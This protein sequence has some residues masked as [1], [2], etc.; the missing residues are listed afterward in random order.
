MANDTPEKKLILVIGATGAQGLAVIDGLLK[1]SADGS[2]SP[3]TIRALTR[4]P[5][6]TRAKEL[7]NRGVQVF[8]GSV[9]DFNSILAALEGVYG[10][11]VNTD[12]FTIG[13]MKEV[14]YG[15]RIFELAKQVGTL[16]HY[17]WSALDYSFKL[18]GYNPTYRAEHYDAKGR[19]ND[20]LRA[21]PHAQ[22]LYVWTVEQAGGRNLRLRRPHGQWPRPDDLAL[23]RRFFA[24]YIFEHR[25]STSAQEL[26]VASDWVDWPYLVST[27]TKVTGKPAV[28]LPLSMDE[29]FGLWNQ[30]D[31][32]LPVMNTKRVADGSTTWE[33]NFRCWWA[34]YR[35]DIVKRDFEWIRKLHPG[36]HTLESWMRETGYDGDLLKNPLKNVEDGKFP[37]LEL[38]LA[39]KL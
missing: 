8:K 24:R 36:G 4:S 25:E 11:Y 33:Q 23:R 31:I 18:G 32:K 30:D 13:E 12:S 7:A 19:I 3:Y 29:W 26:E 21:Q 22:Q 37:R 14:Y 2:P 5:E 15:M 35:D 27:F 6:S 34:Q 28:Y 39:Q 38:S 1:P 10:A 17:V 20:W 16:K 9:D